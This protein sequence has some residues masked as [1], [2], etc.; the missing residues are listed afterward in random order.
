VKGQSQGLARAGIAT[1]QQAQRRSAGGGRCG[2][3][4]AAA[5]DSPVSD[6]A[7]DR[8]LEYLH[9]AAPAQRCLAERRRDRFPPRPSG[10]ARGSGTAR[11]LSFLS[12]LL[13]RNPKQ[14][15]DQKGGSDKYAF[16]G[17]ARLANPMWRVSRTCSCFLAAA[18]VVR[19]AHP[20]AA[21][22]VVSGGGQLHRRSGLQA[23]GM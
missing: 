18:A 19:P 8:L 3:A 21:A 13:H 1:L 12:V 9:H 22:A 14:R 11:A 20:A 23:D 7:S 4:H 16:P 17:P 5:R 15:G 6:S 10:S 2:A